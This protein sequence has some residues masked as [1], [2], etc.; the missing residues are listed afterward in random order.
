MGMGWKTSGR[1]E[2]S[3]RKCKCGNGEVI[4][5]STTEESDYPPFERDSG[6]EIK[7]TCKNNCE[8]NG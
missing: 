2:V 6:Y 7:S 4:T 8:K 1:T 5:Y 3:I